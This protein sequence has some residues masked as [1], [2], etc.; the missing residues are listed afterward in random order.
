MTTSEIKTEITIDFSTLSAEQAFRLG[1][2]LAEVPAKVESSFT[3]EP[4]PKALPFEKFLGKTQ[5]PA[6]EKKDV[7]GRFTENC[8]YPQVFIADLVAHRASGKTLQ[9]IAD[10]LNESGSRTKTQKLWQQMTVWSVVYSRQAKRFWNQVAEQNR[11][12]A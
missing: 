3:S 1:Q 5:G 6:Y 7:P 11:L 2:L 8:N 9:Q 12:L 10:L 4:Q